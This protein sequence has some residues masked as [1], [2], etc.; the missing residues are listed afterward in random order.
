MKERVMNVYS[1][2][3]VR[4]LS[5]IGIACSVSLRTSA[6]AFKDSVFIHAEDGNEISFLSCLSR[7]ELVRTKQVVAYLVESRSRSVSIVEYAE[8]FF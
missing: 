2:L 3:Q 5:S 4:L 8:S 1:R 6:L 7:S